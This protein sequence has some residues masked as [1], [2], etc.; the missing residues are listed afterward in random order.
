MEYMEH[1]QIEMKLIDLRKLSIKYTVVFLVTL[2]CILLAGCGSEETKSNVDLGNEALETM[3]YASALAYF[4]AAASEGEDPKI[5]QR[6]MGMA[7]L[8]LNR[9]QDAVDHFLGA[10]AASDGRIRTIDYDISYYLA[11]AQ[12]KNGDFQGAYDTYTA[13]INLNEKDKTAYY[14]R[15]RVLLSMDDKISAMDDYDRAVMLDPTNYDI[16]IRICKDLTAAGY[17][18]NG[19]AYV[20]RALNTDYKKSDY[21]R[22][23]LSYYVGEYE[24]AR[25][26]FEA[27][28]NEKK[29]KDNKDLILYLCKTYEALNDL[30]YA[31]AL[32]SE[33]LN[34]HP[35][36]A[37]LFLSM[38]LL[39][40]KLEDHDGAL[41][42][43]Q[44]GIALN[45]PEFM[46][47]LKFNE[48]VAYEY[49]HD[50]DKA[51]VLMK[52]YLAL[53]PNDETAQ[54]E[55]EFLQTR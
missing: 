33:Y 32:Y 46:Q 44:A 4:D 50:F 43:F 54:R 47:S 7:C 17:E 21:Q 38:G 48:I 51:A 28:R 36:E 22:G 37:E 31:A 23:V 30:N 55:Y 6:G 20:H 40:L 25:N 8:G 16:Y 13:I 35:E 9:Y 18:D 10:L 24:D 34:Q 26:S 39:K 45:Q 3:D 2:L 42:A 5:T 15:G 53:Y 27:C 52:E 29:Y 12:F 11:V 19:K 1:K 49:L 41:A 14:L